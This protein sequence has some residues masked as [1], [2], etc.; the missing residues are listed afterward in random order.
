MKKIMQYRKGKKKVLSPR[1]GIGLLLGEE[2][3]V[4]K[5]N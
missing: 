4:T 3:S 2:N 1:P 5:F